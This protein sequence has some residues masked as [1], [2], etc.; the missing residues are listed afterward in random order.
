MEFLNGKT[1]I[2]CKHDSI[3][4]LGYLQNDYQRTAIDIKHPEEVVRQ[5]AIYR[6]IN[7]AREYGADALIEPT[8][9][10]NVEQ[11]GKR[12]ITYKSTVTAKILKLKTDR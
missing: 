8:I 2:E 10:T 4:K 12:T 9:S 5:L 7:V 1:G 11:T 3:L 6:L